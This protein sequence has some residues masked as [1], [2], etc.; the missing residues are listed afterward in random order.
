MSAVGVY[1]LLMS[2]EQAIRLAADTAVT[3]LRVDQVC[4]FNNFIWVI[5]V[6]NLFSGPISGPIFYC[7]R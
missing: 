3:I 6:F 2:K 1:D 7:F 4:V 5:C